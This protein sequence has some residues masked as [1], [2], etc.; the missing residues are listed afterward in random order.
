MSAI[1]VS[2]EYWW[3]EAGS[4][5]DLKI[6]G[7]RIA[8]CGDVPIRIEAIGGNGEIAPAGAHRNIVVTDNVITGCAMPGIL[9]TSTA[10]LRIEQN[11]FG[12]WIE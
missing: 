10:G 12:K 9:V 1:L 8:K 2:P 4:S 3:L 6:H 11:E 7:N 5:C